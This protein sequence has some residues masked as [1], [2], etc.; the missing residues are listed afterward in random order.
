MKMELV[1]VAINLLL[2]LSAVGVLV[3]LIVRTE[4][5]LD[6]AFK[7]L[8]ITP[9]V[10]ALASMLQFDQLSGIFSRGYA[11]FIFYASRLIANVAFLVACIILLKTI[12]KESEKK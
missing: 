12:T 4:K 9:I 11:Q 3:R 6:L 2:M 5:G 8:I 7:I 1:M 10:L